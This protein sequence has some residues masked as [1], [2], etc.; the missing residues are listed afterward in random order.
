[1]IFFEFMCSIGKCV[2][3]QNRPFAN[4]PSTLSSGS[5]VLSVFINHGRPE[6]GGAFNYNNMVGAYLWLAAGA[7]I[8]IAGVLAAQLR[9]RIAGFNK[10]TDSILRHLSINAVKTGAVTSSERLDSGRCF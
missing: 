7:D 2:I 5:G 9:L 8:I 4:D 1:M 10:R 6:A 3:S